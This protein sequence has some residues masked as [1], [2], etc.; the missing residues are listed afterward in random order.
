MNYYR[1]EDIKRINKEKGYYFFE[2]DT[3]RFFK[4]RVGDLVFQGNGG[5]FFTTSERFDYD[6]PRYYTVRE[7]NPETGSVNTIGDFNELSYYQARSR[8]KYYA[9]VGINDD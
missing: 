5:V 4:S 8:A 6:T 7:F 2:P 3:M 1:M 9:E